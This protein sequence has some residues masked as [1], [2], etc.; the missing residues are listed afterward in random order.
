MTVHLRTHHLLCLLTYVGQGYTPGFASNM[1]AFVTRLNAGEDAVLVEGPDDICAPMLA[2]ENHCHDERIRARDILA[3]A[4]IT[5]TLGNLDHL[6][7]AILASL[8]DAFA[9]GTIREACRDCSWDD[10]CTTTAANGYA[11]VRLLPPRNASDHVF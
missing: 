7:G 5:S 1:D 10:L 9:A 2:C 4:S 8:R 6:D 3:Q 11:G